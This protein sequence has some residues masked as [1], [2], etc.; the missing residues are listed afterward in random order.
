VLLYL[1]IAIPQP[2]KIIII[3]RLKLHRQPGLILTIIALV[4]RGL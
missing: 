1:G 2:P 3:E 4:D